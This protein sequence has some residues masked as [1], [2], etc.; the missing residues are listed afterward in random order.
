MSPK[1]SL[2]LCAPVL[3]AFSLAGCT[4]APPE[5][6]EPE[7]TLATEC[8]QVTQVELV[9]LASDYP[10]TDPEKDA[11]FSLIGEISDE[12]PEQLSI[13]TSLTEWGS[14][15]HSDKPHVFINTSSPGGNFYTGMSVAES[16]SHFGAEHVTTLCLGQ[17]S[18][19]ASYIMAAAGKSYGYPS[20]AIITHAA[21]FE[22]KEHLSLSSDQ[23]KILAQVEDTTTHAEQ[24]FYQRK[25][26]IA[27]TCTTYLT[28]KTDTP[29][30]GELA[31]KLG[32]LDAVLV[33]GGKMLVRKG[34][35]ARFGPLPAVNP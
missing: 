13:I 28:R 15:D 1:K 26:G 12:N 25:L 31:L 24:L 19:A 29:L 3:L 22:L 6:V 17:A 10:T 23:Q 16:V 2:N 5:P 14:L 34:D 33:E 18:S 35:E 20:C 30:N 27:Q 7:K 11:I 9:E 21:R 8:P 4:E 32:F